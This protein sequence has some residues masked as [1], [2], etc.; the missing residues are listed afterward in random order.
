MLNDSVVFVFSVHVFARI[1]AVSLIV[2]R[3]AVLWRLL[4]QSG[5]IAG[6]A[7]T[8]DLRYDMNITTPACQLASC[9]IRKL[10]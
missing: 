10:A 2:S 8:K 9:T 3:E 1:V 7:L 4:C 6:T 5:V